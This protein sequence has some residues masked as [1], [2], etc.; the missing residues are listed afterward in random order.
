MLKILLSLFLLIFLT[1]SLSA[2]QK[3]NPAFKIIPLGVK[4]GLDEGNLSSYLIAEGG[5]NAYI[6][7]DAG[8]LHEGISKAIAGKVLSGTPDQVLKRNIK[9]YC[10]S[11]GHL[12][13]VSGL[14]L[15]SPNDTSKFIYALPSVIKVLKERYFTWQNWA[16]FTNE[17]DKPALGEYKYVYLEEKKDTIL[18]NTSLSVKAFSLSHGTNY[19]STAFLIHAKG[20]YMLYL[21]DTGADPNEKSDKLEILWKAIA[22]LIKSNTLKAIFLEV[23]FPDEVA[24]KALFGHLNPRLFTKEMASLNTFS[25][26][27]LKNTPIFIT[28][29]KPCLDCE[30]RIKTQLSRENQLGLKLVYPVQGSMIF[31]D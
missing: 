12:D 6:A 16:N 31:L 13:H 20:G 18:N 2:Q 24:D 7:L 23:S 15:N 22:P 11:H 14:I 10:I 21:G 1:I 17:G 25:D 28:H 5:S 8:T 29:M 30:E 3:K 9:G 26:G 4:G 19:E 27:K